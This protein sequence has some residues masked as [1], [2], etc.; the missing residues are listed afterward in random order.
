MRFSLLAK[1]MEKR[2]MQEF[3][4]SKLGYCWGE[5]NFKAVARNI[6]KFTDSWALKVTANE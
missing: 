6:F 1:F 5:L 4:G 2:N 3:S